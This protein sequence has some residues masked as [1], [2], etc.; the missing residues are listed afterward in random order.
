MTFY[1][2]VY[3]ND[4]MKIDTGWLCITALFTREFPKLPCG[5]LVHGNSMFGLDG[6]RRIFDL[7][8]K[9]DSEESLGRA[10]EE[11]VRRNQSEVGFLGVSCNL[12]DRSG[13]ACGTRL[14]REEKCASLEKL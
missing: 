4:A 9:E 12:R 5:S 11:G 13:W 10:W 8:S 1:S 7:S 14:C 3:F 2:P 6:A